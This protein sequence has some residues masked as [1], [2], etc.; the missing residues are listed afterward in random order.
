[1]TS[2]S[3]SLFKIFRDA[4][5]RQGW[6]N[7]PGLL[8][9]VSGGS[10][11]MALLSLAHRCYEGRIVA[12]H[13][14]H[15][16]RGQTSLWDASFVEEHC[17]GIRV[18]CY[19]RHADVPNHMEKGESFE[20]AGRRARYDFFS[21]LLQRENLAF[22]ATGHTA[23]DVVETMLYHL[24]R[25]TGMKGLAGIAPVSGRAVRPLIGCRREQ[26]REFLTDN[27]IPWC[28][29]ET[30]DEN[31]YLRNKIRNQLLP[32]VRANINASPERALLGL[33]SQAASAEAG[34]EEEARRAL[35][36]LLRAHPMAMA[37]W[38]TETAR[39][40]DE[41]RLSAALRLQGANLGLPPLGRERMRELLSLIG[42]KGRWRF[43]WSGE[44]EVCGSRSLIGWIERAVLEPPEEVAIDL[45]VL[46][47]GGK[48]SVRWGRWRIEFAGETDFRRASCGIWQA[49]IFTGP[50]GIVRV[51]S[52]SS[53]V[54]DKIK[55]DRLPWWSLAGWPVVENWL[56]G[57]EKYVREESGYAMIAKV[58]CEGIDGGK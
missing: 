41:A 18:P 7:A 8:V 10:D 4:G 13:L 54:S 30:N 27:G 2:T 14:E 17:R 44:I 23:D 57:V 19:V 22:V 29:D 3:D 51:V 11:S 40:F 52:A 37:A 35:P 38:D 39:R 49:R 42:G 45:S 34:N 33:A 43:Q 16:F 20:M 55:R 15:G 31:C 12:A 56:P 25:G 26:L 24:F 9:A 28:E 58:F 53:A 32:W 36:W 46:R 6:L 47:D 21:E 1:M 48:K 50:S 5:E